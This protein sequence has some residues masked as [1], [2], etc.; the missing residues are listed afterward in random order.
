MDTDELYARFVSST[1]VCTDT[2]SIK[3][4][5]LFFAL[6]GPHFNGN[7]FAASALTA[8]AAYA[9][10]DEPIPDAPPAK[11]IVV[12]NAL[13]SLQNLAAHH[14]KVWAKPIVA[15][16]G[17]NGKTT[18]K[19]L[20]RQVLAA[21]FTVYATPG[22]LNNHIGVPLTLLQLKPAHEVA[23]VE[24]GDNQPGDIAELCEIAQPTHALI[25]NIGLDHIGGYDNLAQNAQTK[26]ELFEDVQARGGV[27]FINQRDAWLQQ[28]A[29]TYNSKILY[30]SPGQY[31][32]GR[33]TGF[34]IEG[35]QY[36]LRFAGNVGV[37]EKQQVLGKSRLWGTYNLSNIEA[38]AAVGHHMGCTPNEIVQ[39]VSAYV[40][41]NNRSQII[42]AGGRVLVMDAYNANPS[43]LQPALEDWFSLPMKHKSVV[44]GDMLELGEAAEQEHSTIGK[45]LDAHPDVQAVLIG[46][47][48]IA[49]YNAIG[50][51]NKIHFETTSEAVVQASNVLAGA[52]FVLLKGSRGMAVEKVA[53]A[54]KG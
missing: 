37:A 13:L 45:M 3:Q 18:T 31:V 42:Q 4:G 38:A 8:G 15:I 54:L 43:S 39:A 49:A 22:N 9:I 40:P 34:D 30:G 16:T 20:L 52:K 25:T 7:A 46:P 5:Q 21:R 23:I 26:L 24:L 53:Q 10:V 19:E 36:E 28:A 6:R 17:S 50:H 32:W 41:D 33:V 11:V 48:M 27:L 1:G 44:L 47:L 35:L 12:Q 51:T 2:R 14:R 29:L